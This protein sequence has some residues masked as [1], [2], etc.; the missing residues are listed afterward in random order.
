MTY[1]GKTTIDFLAYQK[2][3]SLIYRRGLF[4]LAVVTL[5]P[6]TEALPDTGVASEEQLESPLKVTARLSAEE[7]PVDGSL[8]LIVD[9]VYFVDSIALSPAIPQLRLERLL[10]HSVSTSTR[11]V[12]GDGVS[13][14]PRVEIRQ[15]R[16]QLDATRSGMAIIQPLLITYLTLPDSQSGATRTPELSAL[17]TPPAKVADSPLSYWW[18]LALLLALAPAGWWLRRRF[19]P[20]PPEDKSKKEIAERLAELK[21]L[22]GGERRKFFEAM[23]RLLYDLCQRGFQL[24]SSRGDTEALIAELSSTN[25]P[26]TSQEKLGAWLRISGAE[27]FASR[28]ATP[29]ETLRIYYELEPFVLSHWPVD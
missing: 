5:L 10:V 17:I 16:Y 7:T 11:L 24:T 25:L 1:P 23:Y 14:A 22:T 13:A 12:S 3:Q 15:F 4:C 29:G 9:L 6:L 8:E 28:S 20:P 2:P 27:R 18:F 26:S 21:T 19:T